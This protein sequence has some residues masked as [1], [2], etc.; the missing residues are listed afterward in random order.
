MLSGTQNVEVAF[1][2]LNKQDVKMLIS[3]TQ[4]VELVHPKYWHII[5]STFSIQVQHFLNKVVQ[6]K[7]YE[8]SEAYLNVR[9]S[10]SKMLKFKT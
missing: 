8:N 10:S 3:R 1:Q 7:N 2:I 5:L 4:N 6:H 9:I